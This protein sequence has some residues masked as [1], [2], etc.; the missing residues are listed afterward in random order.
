MK[1]ILSCESEG[2]RRRRGVSAK[3]AGA[4]PARDRSIASA[5]KACARREELEFIE[6]PKVVRRTKPGPASRR[7]QKSLRPS[8][9]EQG[10]PKSGSATESCAAMRS[11]GSDPV[12]LL[13]EGSTGG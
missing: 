8:V 2:L 13:R 4:R 11:A 12:R 6:P 7:G 9:T 5:R 3:A 10:M 1:A